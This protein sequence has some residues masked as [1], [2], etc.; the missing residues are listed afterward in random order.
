MVVFSSYEVEEWAPYLEEMRARIGRATWKS[1]DR[2]TVE[3]LI[4]Q[5]V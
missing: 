1:L 5:K 2:S 3:V 4:R